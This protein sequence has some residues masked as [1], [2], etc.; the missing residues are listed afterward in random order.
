MRSGG[1]AGH[2]MEREGVLYMSRKEWDALKKLHGKISL[3][4]RTYTDGFLFVFSFLTDK[5]IFSENELPAK[6]VKR[7]ESL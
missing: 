6:L 4:Q 1:V 7:M 2:R 5:L 3:Q